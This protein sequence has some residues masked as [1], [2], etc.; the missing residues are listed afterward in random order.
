MINGFILSVLQRTAHDDKLI[1]MCSLLVEVG[2]VFAEIA[3]KSSLATVTK[4]C[5][6][7]YKKIKIISPIYGCYEETQLIVPFPFPLVVQV[8]NGVIIFIILN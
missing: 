2:V 5:L 4:V 3:A 1:I 7:D 6:N 8:F